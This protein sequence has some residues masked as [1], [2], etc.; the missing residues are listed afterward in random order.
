MYGE[1]VNFKTYKKYKEKG[2]SGISIKTY[3]I[4]SNEDKRKNTEKYV[5]L[6]LKY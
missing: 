6:E 3:S 2:M 5:K 1:T 4:N